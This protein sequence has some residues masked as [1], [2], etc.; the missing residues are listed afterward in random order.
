MH[1]SGLIY[2][3]RIEEYIEKFVNNPNFL[4]YIMIA[5][6]AIIRCVATISSSIH[7]ICIVF[8]GRFLRRL[9]ILRLTKHVWMRGKSI[10]LLKTAKLASN[11]WPGGWQALRRVMKFTIIKRNKQ[12]ESEAFFKNINIFL[13]EISIFQKIFGEYSIFSKKLWIFR[14]II[15]KHQ[16]SIFIEPPYKS[17]ARFWKVS[18]VLQGL[19]MGSVR[20]C[21]P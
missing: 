17:R 15:L 10:P 4:H 18:G 20:Y 13:L 16:I 3:V 6:E 21:K 9:C 7:H 14:K 1:I 11:N 19:I 5:F 12:F 2:S 8:W